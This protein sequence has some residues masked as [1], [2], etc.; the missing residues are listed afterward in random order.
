MGLGG[1][2]GSSAAPCPPSPHPLTLLGTRCPGRG[3][4][5]LVLESGTSWRGG[6]GTQLDRAGGGLGRTDGTF[7]PSPCLPHCLMAGNAG[8]LR[9]L[10][11]LRDR[12]QRGVTLLGYMQIRLCPLSP[13]PPSPL[14]LT[15]LYPQSERSDA[16]AGPSPA[17]APLHKQF[18]W[19]GM[20]FPPF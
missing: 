17:S 16:L 1:I 7:C 13:H 18:L 10:G 3:L 9:G 14:A 19:P 4:R 8:W 5:S 11:P 20:P 15:A 6:Q 12:A 2:T